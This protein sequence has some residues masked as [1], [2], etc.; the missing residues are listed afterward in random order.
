MKM[1]I[2]IKTNIAADSIVISL[3]HIHV[4][5]TTYKGRI[6]VSPSNTLNRMKIIRANKILS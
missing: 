6:K 1:L 2:N 3:K 5:N 4:R